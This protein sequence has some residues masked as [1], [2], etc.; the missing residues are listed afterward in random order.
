[1]NNDE[2]TKLLYTQ[3]KCA[4]TMNLS[5]YTLATEASTTSHLIYLD[6]EAAI[7]IKTLMIS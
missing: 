5:S 6:T 7:C 4:Q 1:M 2:L 3:G